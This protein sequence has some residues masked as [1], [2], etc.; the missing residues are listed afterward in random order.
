MSQTQN[1]QIPGGPVKSPM[2]IT[3]AIERSDVSS[4]VRASPRAF[5]RRHQSIDQVVKAKGAK[6]LIVEPSVYS[7]KKSLRKASV[8]IPESQLMNTQKK[9]KIFASR[10]T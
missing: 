2:N 10:D 6:K 3:A 9:Q 1:F 7:F 5:K 4:E 8:S